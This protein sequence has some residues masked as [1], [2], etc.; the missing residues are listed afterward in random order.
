[1]CSVPTE[2]LSTCMSLNLE[3]CWPPNGLN[4]ML[5][6]YIVTCHNQACYVQIYGHILITLNAQKSGNSKGP[7]NSKHLYHA[8]DKIR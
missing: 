1:M 2:P 8:A 5:C 4:S 6:L 7:E 3:G